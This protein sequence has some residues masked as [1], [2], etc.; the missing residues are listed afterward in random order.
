MI[1]G[2]IIDEIREKADIVSIVSEYVKLKKRGKNYLGLCPFHSEKTPSFT[3][4]PEKKLF[5]CFGCK[6]GG[7]IFAFIM[8]VESLS[9]SEAARFLGDKL[10]ISVP[11]SGGSGKAGRWDGLRDIVKMASAFYQSSLA[12]SQEGSEARNYLKEREIKEGAAKDFKLGL[13]PDGWDSLTK[14]LIQ[15]GVKPELIVESGLAIAKE[16]GGLY[17]RFRGRLMFP[18]CDVRGREIGFGAR[19]LGAGEPKYINSPETPVYSKSRTLYGMDLSKDSI[20]KANS[21]VIVEGNMDVITCHQSGFR[22]VV[23]SMGT[24]LT[25]DQVKLLQRFCS[26]VILAYDSDAAGGKATERGVELLKKAGFGVRVAEMSSGKDPDEIIRRLGPDQFRRA[27]EASVP[28]LQYRIS[29]VLRKSNLNEIES[30]AKA[31]REVASL[32]SREP[33]R[34]VRAEYIKYVSSE[35]GTSPEEIASEVKRE[36]YYSGKRTASSGRRIT[37]RP[38]HKTLKAEQ[39]ILQLAMENAEALGVLKENLHWG[40]FTEGITRTIAELLLNV[41]VEKEKD[42]LHFLHDNLPTEEAKKKLSEIMMA[43]HPPL[44]EKRAIKDYITTIK[45]HNLRAKISELRGSLKESERQNEIDR[46][47]VLHR[48]LA[49]C[50]KMLRELEKTV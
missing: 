41:D 6:E 1:P 5:H 9:F 48:E 22:N 25:E 11:V 29:S 18:I 39:A 49:E 45:A 37:E 3:V 35:L 15:K 50:S 20:R 7:N 30:R 36:K 32:I 28:W 42:I 31:V 46:S 34:L 19:I 38:Q 43:E 10:G 12:A 44:D 17:D 40:E 2:S 8:K 21:A 4:S 24:A 33:D 27:L 14:H 26:N 47:K 23:A 13:S 16:S